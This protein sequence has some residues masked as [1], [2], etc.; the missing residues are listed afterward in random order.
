MMTVMGHWNRL[1]RET[2]YAPVSESVYGQV[3]GGFD[4][5]DLM[6]DVSAFDRG[7]GI[8]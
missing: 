3:G 8:K 2:I 1:S 6:K 7:V 4:Q 5:P